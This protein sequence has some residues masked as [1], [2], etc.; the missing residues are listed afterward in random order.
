MVRQTPN[1]MESN[2]VYTIKGYIGLERIRKK[3]ANVQQSR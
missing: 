2:K 1:A 3:V